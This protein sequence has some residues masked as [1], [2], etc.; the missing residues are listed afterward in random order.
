[1]NCKDENLANKHTQIFLKEK[2]QEMMQTIFQMKLYC[3]RWMWEDDWW[4][5]MLFGMHHPKNKEEDWHGRVR[6]DQ[7]QLYD[8]V[9][10]Q[11]HHFVGGCE[12]RKDDELYHSSKKIW[13]KNEFTPLIRLNRFDFKIKVR[14]NILLELNE[15]WEC[16]IFKS[17]GK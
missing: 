11:P 4:D 13:V 2:S 7:S 14:F 17:N 10:A 9:C 16:I 8:G 1:M 6:W 15:N 12:D 5:S 3:A